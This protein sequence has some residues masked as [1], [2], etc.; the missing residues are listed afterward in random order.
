MFPKKLQKNLDQRKKANNFREMKVYDSII[1]FYSN[2]YLGLRTNEILLEQIA[3]IPQK[4]GSG[5]SRLMSGTTDNM[6]KCE[7]YLAQYYQ[8]EAALMYPSGYMANLGLLAAIGTKEDTIIYDQFMHASTREGIR[9]SR[10]RS[11]SFRHNDMSDLEKKLQKATGEVYVLVEGI[12]SMQGDIAP[13][14]DLLKLQEKYS[15]YL[16][17][18]EAH[19]VGVIGNTLKGWSEEF[20]TDRVFAKI[21][22]FGKAIGYHGAIVVGSQK[23]KEFLINFSHSFIYT[24]APPETQFQLLQIIH[25]WIARNNEILKSQLNDVIHYYNAQCNDEKISPIKI[26][27]RPDLEEVYRKFT[28]E[29]IQTKIIKTPTVEEGQEIIRLSLHANHN[30]SQLDQLIKILR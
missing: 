18:D 28:I 1:D 4:M 23:L 30:Q 27:K 9:L 7:Y 15:F 13:Q 21:I 6:L 2:D 20:P 24:T 22:T 29:G 17:V 16:I 14:E 26:I 3:K 11:F 19:S 12:Y 5:G 8:D 10:A 25:E